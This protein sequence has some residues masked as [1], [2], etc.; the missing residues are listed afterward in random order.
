MQQINLKHTFE[1]VF[2]KSIYDLFWVLSALIRNVLF[3]SQT[4]S[5]ALYLQGHFISS[6]PFLWHLHSGL[7]FH[8][9]FHN[10]IQGQPLLRCNSWACCLTWSI[11][12]FVLSLI[13]DDR[14]HGNLMPLY[15]LYNVSKHYL[16]FVILLFLL[17]C[18]KTSMWAWRYIFLIYFC[19]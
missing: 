6:R 12:Q 19:T 16:N 1:L 8:F 14:L 2:E 13:F 17:D 5:P 15:N 10:L 7:Y 9:T 3:S 4:F 11:S 18:Q